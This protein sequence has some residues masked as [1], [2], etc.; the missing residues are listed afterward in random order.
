M[1]LWR[2]YEMGWRWSWR[3]N[4]FHT[5]LH[6]TP[7]GSLKGGEGCDSLWILNRPV[8]F[9]TANCDIKVLSGLSFS[10]FLLITGALFVCPLEVM[11]GLSS[12]S[13]RPIRLE[14]RNDGLKRQE[15]SANLSRDKARRRRKSFPWHFSWSFRRP[16]SYQSGSGYKKKKKKKYLG[17]I[18]I[19]W[20]FIGLHQ[21]N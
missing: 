10:S 16:C 2:D 18:S 4:R 12:E 6:C 8:T 14:V 7:R 3:I 17:E 15:I 19:Q 11:S 9:Q 1:R 13:F 5:T 20:T 21:W